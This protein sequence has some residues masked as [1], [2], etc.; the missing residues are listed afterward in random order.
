[1]TAQGHEDR[2]PPTR[3]SAVYGFGKQT[4]AGGRNGRDAPITA[5]LRRTW[6]LARPTRAN[7][8]PCLRIIRSMKKRPFALDFRT[9]SPPQRRLIRGHLSLGG[10][11]RLGEF[12]EQRLG[13]F[14]VG[15]IE[16]FGKPAED[17]GEQCRRLLRFALAS[18]L[19]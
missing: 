6:Q 18:T 3:L 7:S 4:I 16:P 17:W 10:N 8:R 12:V 14:E 15:G 13:L 5:I 2:F 1:M 11:G 9:S 19:A